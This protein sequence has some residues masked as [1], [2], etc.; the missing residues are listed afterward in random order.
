MVKVFLRYLLFW[1]PAFT[2]SVFYNNNSVSSQALQCFTAFF[3]L[4]AWAV[5]TGAFAYRYPR[6]ALVF[7]LAFGGAHIVLIN[8]VYRTTGTLH[9]ILRIICGLFTF[10]PLNIFVRM[11][12]PYN[13]LPHEQIII[14]ALLFSCLLGYLF[15]AVQ[16]R[17]NPNP[18]SPR[19]MR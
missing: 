8:M 10:R 13:N 11:L 7:L 16:R 5:N 3:M 17:V 18:Y 6:A 4:L 19:M 9:T 2:I 15:G 12:Q 14:L 1:F